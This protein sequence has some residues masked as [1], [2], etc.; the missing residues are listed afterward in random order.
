MPK[1]N[2]QRSYSKT[3]SGGHNHFLQAKQDN[4]EKQLAGELSEDYKQYNMNHSYTQCRE[5]KTIQKNI[6][7]IC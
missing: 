5:S 2:L 6:L 4:A 3:G 7:K 1:S